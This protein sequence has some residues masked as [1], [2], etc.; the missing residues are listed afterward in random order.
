VT[1]S[2]KAPIAATQ[3]D[4]SLFSMRR[5]P[6]TPQRKLLNLDKGRISAQL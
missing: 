1:G 2:A 5:W 3:P 4:S 6:G